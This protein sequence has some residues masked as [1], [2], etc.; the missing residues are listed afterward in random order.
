MR[1]AAVAVALCAALAFPALAAAP[2]R[3][4]PRGVGKVKLGAKH[5]RL[6]AEGLVGPKMQGC[7]VAGPR[8]RAAVLKPPLK[9]AVELTRRSPR[10][11]RTILVSR[12]A[13]ARGVAIGDTRQDILDAYPKARFD[14]ST[15]TVFGVTIAHIPKGGGGRLEMALRKGRVSLFGIPRITFCE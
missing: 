1:I 5:S 13:T 14:S 15:Q 7:E 12:G 8:E 10:R 11:V 9:G 2:K 4:T 3:I 6:R